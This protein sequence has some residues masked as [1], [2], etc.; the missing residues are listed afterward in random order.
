MIYQTL[1]NQSSTET[2][3]DGEVMYLTTAGSSIKYLYCTAQSSRTQQQY[4]RPALN[5]SKAKNSALGECS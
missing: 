4:K 3:V 2:T 1:E 5:S